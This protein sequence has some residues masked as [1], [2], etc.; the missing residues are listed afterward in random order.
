MLPESLSN[1]HFRIIGKTLYGLEDILSA[2]LAALGA[3]KITKLTRSIEFWGDLELLYKVNIWCR[4]ATRF[5]VPVSTFRASDPDQLYR[6][7]G[8][9]DWSKYLA[10]RDRF[11]IDPVVSHS[12]FRHSH[13]VAQKAKDA[14]VD[15]FRKRTGKRPSV[16]AADP[17][18]RINLHI[19][20]NN[21]TLSFDSSGEALHRRGYRTEGGEAPINEV[22]AA[23]ILQMTEWDGSSALVDGMCGSGTFVIEAAMIARRIAPGMVGRKFGFQRWRNYDPDLFRRLSEEAKQCVLPKASHEILGSDISS[24]CLLEATA[25]AGRAGVANDIRFEQKPFAEQSPPPAPG[26]LV[27]N[28][29]YG[30]RLRETNI[31]EFYQMIGDTLK[32][33]YDGYDAFILTGNL[34]AAKR[35]GLRTSRRIKLYNGPLECRLFKYEIYKGSRKHR[36]PTP[37]DSAIEDKE[38]E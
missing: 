15:Q 32:G 31:V 19:H 9:L 20:Q 4:T 24:K 21:A 29:P 22:L 14:I 37:P 23:G 18:L 26:M 12:D 17:D 11:V 33:N 3:V 7:V 35:L 1:N 36:P 28:P 10:V 38:T 27:M 6:A 13:F 8:K 25:N 2:E 30:E 16:D 34:D 5:L